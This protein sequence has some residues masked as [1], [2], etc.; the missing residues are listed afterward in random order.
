LPAA[1]AQIGA[2]AVVSRERLHCGA[3]GVALNR[4]LQ[5][6][7]KRRTDEGGSV[8]AASGGELAADGLRKRARED[9][10]AHWASL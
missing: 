7:A 5:R 4:I 1:F 10:G 8:A 3:G 9:I 6:I 2:S